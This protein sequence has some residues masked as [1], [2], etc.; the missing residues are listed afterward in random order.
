MTAIPSVF[1]AS[2]KA[3]TMGSCVSKSGSSYAPSNA[4]PCHSPRAARSSSASA[5]AFNRGD[6]WEAVARALDN[7]AND[8]RIDNVI[9]SLAQLYPHS[10]TLRHTLASV[11]QQGGVSLY[12]VHDGDLSNSYGH[13]ETVR[14]TRTI[15]IGENA[16][17]NLHGSFYHRLNTCLIELTN[18]ARA[19]EFKRVRKSFIAGQMA[20]ESAARETERTEYGTIEHMMRYYQ[21]AS[22][23]IAQLGYGDP[24]Q[25]YMIHDPST[26]RLRPAYASFD[27]YF[28]NAQRTG[29]TDVYIQS[30]TALADRY[31]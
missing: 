31:R 2:T 5:S 16:L 15:R 24:F 27:D 6:D 18:L 11:A 28:A 1:Y 25:W 8:P 30:Y 23:E 12:A 9:A 29:H 21:E 17:S 7:P 26:Q 4:S 13:A 20:I 19:E 22:E 10:A 3:I 14:E